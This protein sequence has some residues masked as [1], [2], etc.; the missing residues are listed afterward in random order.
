MKRGQTVFYCVLLRTLF[1]FYPN[2][3]P[4][5]MTIERGFYGQ[6]TFENTVFH[7]LVLEIQCEWE[8]TK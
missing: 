2:R 7:I 4:N 8:H 1:L 3:I 5:R 6:I